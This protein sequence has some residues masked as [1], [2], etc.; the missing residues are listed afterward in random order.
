VTTV[1]ERDDN[2][3]TFLEVTRRRIRTEG[4]NDPIAR[5]RY[6]VVIEVLAPFFDTAELAQRAARL[7]ASSTDLTDTQLDTLRQL[8]DGVEPVE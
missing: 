7:L 6:E 5:V 8:V 2:F 3:L 1:T 4:G